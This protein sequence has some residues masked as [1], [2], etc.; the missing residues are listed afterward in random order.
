VNEKNSFPFGDHVVGERSKFY[1]YLSQTRASNNEQRLKFSRPIFAE[2][3]QEN[4]IRFRSASHKLHC[5]IW[6]Y[7]NS[8]AARET[9]SRRQKPLNHIYIYLT[10]LVRR[11]KLNLHWYLAL[12]VTHGHWKNRYRKNDLVLIFFFLIFKYFVGFFFSER[13]LEIVDALLTLERKLKLGTLFH[14]SLILDFCCTG[15]SAPRTAV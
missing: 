1:S 2:D 14:S 6:I 7:Y 11:G 8:S 3:F 4:Y 15:Y 12:N 10:G 13:I 5:N 9:G